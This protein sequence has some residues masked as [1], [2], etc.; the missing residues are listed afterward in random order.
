MDE[1]LDVHN[2]KRYKNLLETSVDEIERRT[3]QKMLDAEEAKQALQTSA[4]RVG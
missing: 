3:I 4:P 1:S 2:I